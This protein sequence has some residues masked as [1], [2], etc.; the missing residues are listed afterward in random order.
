MTKGAPAVIPEVLAGQ[1]LSLV[2]R[3]GGHTVLAASGAGD[4]ARDRL[5]VLLQPIAADGETEEDG[6][7]SSGRSTG[8]EN[9]ER[10]RHALVVSCL[11]GQVRTPFTA[12][13][14]LACCLI[15]VYLWFS[16]DPRHLA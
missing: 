1:V 16:P 11:P 2:R 7:Q 14:V 6:G 13:D 10:P 15:F 5:V 9:D 3:G 12:T 4:L 8:L